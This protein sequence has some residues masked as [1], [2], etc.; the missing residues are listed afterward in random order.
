MEYHSSAD[1]MA[2]ANR[3][4]RLAVVQAELEQIQKRDGPYRR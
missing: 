4:L 3:K 2:E 1:R